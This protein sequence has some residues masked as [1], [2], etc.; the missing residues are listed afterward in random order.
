MFKG[1]LALT[2]TYR[3]NIMKK[4][5]ISL[6]LISICGISISFAQ[7]AL[8][9]NVWP[10]RVDLN[11]VPGENRTGVITVDNKG[12]EKVRVLCYITDIDMDKF[13]NLLFPEG[14]TLS[15]SCEPWLLVNPEDFTLSQGTNQRVR[16]TLKVPDNAAGTFL[17]SIFF[18]SKPEGKSQ[19]TGSQLTVRV[20]TIFV[21]NVIG[22][23]FKS[24]ELTALSMN[25]IGKENIAQVEL[26]FKNKGNLLVRPKGTVEI[27]NEA[28]WTVDK[29]VINEDNQAVL[30]YA[31]RIIRIPIA[32]IRPGSYDLIAMVDYGGSEILSG[33]LKVKLIAAEAP[34][35]SW[36]IPE[37]K[38][39]I[40]TTRQPVK[41][42]E[43]VAKASPEEIKNL[44]ALATKQYTSG[45][46]QASLATWQ[47]LLRVDPGNSTARKNMER[48]KAKLDALKKIKG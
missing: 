30:P 15:Q 16:Y 14:G 33:E 44:Y 8:S 43:P 26:G 29:L 10:P 23:G 42:A 4:S 18:Q 36:P 35:H 38:A 20:G 28:G 46:Y 9:L 39:P 17:A 32:N 34:R 11:V 25:N 40:K 31:E 6:L 5:V 48:T 47:K 22:T 13:G 45:D 1:C 19:T 24:G 41:K 7:G 2:L 37:P 12:S 3:H 21:I 27:K